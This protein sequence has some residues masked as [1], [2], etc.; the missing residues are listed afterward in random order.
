MSGGRDRSQEAALAREGIYGVSNYNKFKIGRLI[1]YSDD[2][3]C[4][5]ESV[6][7]EVARGY[8]DGSSETW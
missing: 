8:P 5:R 4:S 1:R 3:L 2:K 6:L 7:T